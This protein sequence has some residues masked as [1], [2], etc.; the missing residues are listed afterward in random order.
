MRKS[1]KKIAEVAEAYVQQ[2]KER[3][4]RAEAEIVY[5]SIGGGDVWV[6]IELP[7]EMRD[8]RPKVVDATI[9]LN[10]RYSDE[11]GVNVVATVQAREAVTHG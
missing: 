9:D 10:F 5:E 7:P 8:Q 6:N 3:F 1:R 4:P 2:L 11:T